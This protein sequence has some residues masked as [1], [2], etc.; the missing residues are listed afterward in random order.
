MNPHREKDVYRRT[1]LFEPEQTTD[2]PDLCNTGS[3]ELEG[4]VY[5]YRTKTRLA[6]DAGA[7]HWR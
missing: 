5:V 7:C 6:I 3:S 4:Q 1:G 2:I